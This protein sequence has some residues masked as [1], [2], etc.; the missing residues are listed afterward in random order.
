MRNLKT[1]LLFQI[2]RQFLSLIFKNSGQFPWV[3]SGK[4]GHRHLGGLFGS[5][6][7]S[8]SESMGVGR[9]ALRTRECQQQTETGRRAPGFWEGKC[10]GLGASVPRCRVG[11]RGAGGR[12]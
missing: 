11:N 5:L 9:S 8:P 10:Q 4:K 6:K 12:G 7:L 1:L 3:R 2:L